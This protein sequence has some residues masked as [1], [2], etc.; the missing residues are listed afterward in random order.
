L[1][2]E[3]RNI[4]QRQS[5]GELDFKEVLQ[6]ADSS[7]DAPSFTSANRHSSARKRKLRHINGSGGERR[8]ATRR[9]DPQIS[10][11][12]GRMA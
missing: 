7:S 3:V 2:L 1:A 11:R 12:A 10:H 5:L 6:F 8:R 9:S 4:R